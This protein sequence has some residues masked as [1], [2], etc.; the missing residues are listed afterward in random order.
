MRHRILS[1]YLTHWNRKYFNK[2]A[3]FI[4]EQQHAFNFRG[5]TI[6]PAESLLAR[7][8]EFVLN[9]LLG[10]CKTFSSENN[11]KNVLLFFYRGKSKPPHR[12]SK[13]FTLIAIDYGKEVQ[14]NFVML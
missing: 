8:L 9:K 3:D 2:W 6:A 5:K 12:I 14:N 7:N 13:A 4:E 10:R 1:W 11:V